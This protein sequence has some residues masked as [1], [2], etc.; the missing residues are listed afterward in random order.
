MEKYSIKKYTAMA[1][2][3]TILLLSV[4]LDGCGVVSIIDA[5]DSLQETTA[6]ETERE[7]ERLDVFVGDYSAQV[8]GFMSDLTGDKYN[9]ATAKIITAKKSLVMPDDKM[10]KVMSDELTERN[11]QLEQ[12]LGVTLAC[13]ERDADTM[14]AEI[15]AADKSGDYYADVI[16]YPQSM[17]GAFVMGGAVINMKGLPGFE[18]D[19][20]YY[21]E[22]AVA[23]GT[24]GD[25]VYAVAGS[26]SLDP[27]SLSCIYFNKD[28][29]KKLGLESPYSLVD[30]GEWTLNKYVEYSKAASGHKS[31]YNAYSAPNTIEYMED[32]FFFGAGERFTDSTLGEFPVLRPVTDKSKAI[33][34]KLRV[35]TLEVR[36]TALEVDGIKE[37]AK[38]NTLFLID[39]LS[40]AKTLANAKTDWG[41]VP[42]PKYDENQENYYSLSYSEEAMFFGAVATA[43]NYDMT[44]DI[45]AGI[46]IMSYGYTEDAYVKDYTY[47]YLR[48]NS[49]VRMVDTIVKNPVFDLAYSFAG[50]YGSISSATFMALR[51]A[52]AVGSDIENNVSA[53]TGSFNSAMYSL[54][55][56]QE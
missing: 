51:L 23:A 13:E 46:N 30:K 8:D 35:A 47:Y 50:S 25:A 43:P 2:V 17:I 33:V 10:S 42:V 5:P 36:T 1:L 27:G 48:D 19:C 14:L 45:I 53:S 44:A 40:S 20:G 49:S 39:K 3:L 7:P 24:G 37:F 52:V 34:E 15:R 38:G 16:M 6:K 22:T 26:A 41:I 29:I 21:Y 18:T 11:K 9:S 4:L 32:I 56:T 54:F 12:L 28:M 55:E 31:G